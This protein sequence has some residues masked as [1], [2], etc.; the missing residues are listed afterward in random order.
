MK[1]GYSLDLSELKGMFEGKAIIWDDVGLYLVPPK[2]CFTLEEALVCGDLHF[3]SRYA[4]LLH[5]YNL[6]MILS[7]LKTPMPEA[8][9][10]VSVK[11]DEVEKEMG[12]N[13]S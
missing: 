9:V 3:L 5:L 6:L 12:I 10:Y 11:I 7:A 13:A 1:E 4:A 8:I 2:I